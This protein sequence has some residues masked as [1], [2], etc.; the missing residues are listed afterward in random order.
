[1]I[2]ID[3]SL[4]IA[5]LLEE[6]ALALAPE[7]NDLIERETFVVPAHWTAEIGNGLVTNL[8]RRRV[9]A[10]KIKQLIGECSFL[11]IAVEPVT[12]IAQLA[13][14]TNLASAHNLTFYDAAYVQ[15][16]LDRSIP[17]GTLDNR[18]RDAARLL[19]IRLFPATVP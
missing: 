5:W 18:M 12:S 13:P 6:S 11:E 4:M 3:A 2:V 8:R 9:S 16:A 7:L 14:I 19:G 17:L 15:L 10:E 1:L